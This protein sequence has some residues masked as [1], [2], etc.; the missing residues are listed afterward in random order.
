VRIEVWSDIACPWC[1]VGKHHLEAALRGSGT[2]ADVQLRS[3]ELAPD[4]KGSQPA[5]AYLEKRL[6]GA[7][8]VA[9]AHERLSQ[10]GERAG[11]HYDFERALVASTFDAHRVHHFAQTKGRGPETVERLMRAYHGEGADLSD[12]ATIHRLAVE[13]GLDGAEVERVLSSDAFAKEVR[14]DEARAIGL[15][16]QGVPFFLIDGKYGISGA[17]PVEVFLRAIEMVRKGD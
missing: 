5:K 10:I 11:I 6:G 1:W 4:R 8:R 9:M 17:Q 13:A 3:F 12:H 15:G 7:E 16:I 14:E 2:D